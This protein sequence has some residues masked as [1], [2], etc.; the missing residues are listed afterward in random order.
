MTLT[1]SEI[2]HIRQ[3]VA[4]AE[5]RSDVAAAMTAAQQLKLDEI[6]ALLVEIG[7]PTLD[8][9]LDATILELTD[10]RDRA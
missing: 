3:V 10:I 7:D 6:T 2:L 1:L 8:D 4:G 5:V 9:E